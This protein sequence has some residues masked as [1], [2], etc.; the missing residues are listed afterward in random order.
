MC[1]AEDTL[2]SKT[3]PVSTHTFMGSSYQIYGAVVVVAAGLVLRVI[4]SETA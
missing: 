2:L 4:Q 3:P 1:F